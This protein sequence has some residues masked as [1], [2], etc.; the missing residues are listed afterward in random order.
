VIPS[1]ES[2]RYPN[3]ETVAELLDWRPPHGVVSLCL[4]IRPE[5]RSAAW[6]TEARNGLSRIEDEFGDHDGKVAARATAERLAEELSAELVED[7]P[8][9]LL[10]FVEI[11]R[12]EG[13]ERWYRSQLAPRQS[14]V[15]VG[16][17]AHVH[18]LLE[19]LDDGAPLGVAAVSSERVRLFGWRLGKLDELHDWEM[20]Y[21][22]DQWRE[23]KAQRVRD[24]ARSQAV[25]ASGRD[26]FDQRMEANRE[27]F[28]KH[29]GE[30]VRREFAEHRWRRVLAFGDER[31]VRGF[32]QGFGDAAALHHA[33]ESDLV[34]E[35]P[36]SVERRVEELL[37]ELNRERERALIERIKNAAYAKDRGGSLGPEETLQALEE[38]RVDHL[39]YDSERL[40]PGA[41]RRPDGEQDDGAASIERM[42]ELALATSAAV[43]PVE[44]DCA[45]ELSEQD[46]VAALLRY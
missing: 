34:S 16:A 21:F 25:S 23:R 30:L 1:P 22:A 2:L 39:V 27:R 13:E 17:V 5:D 12:Q 31:Y 35:P 38:G 29:T 14:S 46:G 8:R 4:D 44:G 24:P 32:G 6:R 9:G 18:P 37:P 10:G 15:S 28:S 36:G 20:S 41:G 33:A 40:Y 3:R 45:A 11:S 7:A 19:L 26:Q 42:V 43:T